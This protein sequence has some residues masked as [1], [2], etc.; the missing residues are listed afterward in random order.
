MCVDFQISFCPFSGDVKMGFVTV[1]WFFLRLGGALLSFFFFAC[2]S[3]LLGTGGAA[4]L[5]SFGWC[6]LFSLLCGAA[7]LLFLSRCCCFLLSLTLRPPCAVLLA[8]PPC[9]AAVLPFWRCR[10]SLLALGCATFPSFWWASFFPS[11]G[12]AVPFL[13]IS[14]FPS[15]LQLFLSYY[16]A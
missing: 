2:L 14:R 5:R 4:I 3:S 10:C 9:G 8:L 1:G 12:A 16:S 13:V 7:C 11:G 15:F 6:C